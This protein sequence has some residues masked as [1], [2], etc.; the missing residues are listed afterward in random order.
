MRSSLRRNMET[1]LSKYNLYLDKIF[2]KKS[3]QAKKIY[4]KLLK[5][6]K[7]NKFMRKSS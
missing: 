3:V 5:K 7:R 1:L 2:S 6:E 4:N